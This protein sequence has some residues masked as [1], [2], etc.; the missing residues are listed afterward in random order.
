MRKQGN[1]IRVN[2]ICRLV[3]LA[4]A[5]L[6]S[7]VGC[8]AS[9]KEEEQ[10]VHLAVILGAPDAF[11]ALQIRNRVLFLQ[12]TKA[13]LSREKN[14]SIA[15]DRAR[16]ILEEVDQLFQSMDLCRREML[17]SLSIGLLS[18]GRWPASGCTER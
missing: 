4:L 2:N 12:E 3:L 7:A 5:V 6:A 1:R 8:G 10:A 16:Q 18:T 15:E 9:K 17:G 13:G 14:R 11:Y